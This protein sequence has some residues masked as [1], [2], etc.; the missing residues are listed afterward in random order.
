MSSSHGMISRTRGRN[1]GHMDRAC[2]VG[3]LR[4]RFSASRFWQTVADH[5][6]TRVVLVPSL[7]QVVL[8]ALS[9]GAIGPPALW[10]WTTSGEQLS[11]QTLA[12]FRRLLPGATLLNLY[13]STEVMGD[14]T[15][16]ECPSVSSGNT[17]TG[18]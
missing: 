13:G 17:S 10:H 2:G 5:R 6:V 1:L 12:E 18:V 16:Y 14:A 4:A 8:E 7:L 11:R 3:P 9:S 15:A